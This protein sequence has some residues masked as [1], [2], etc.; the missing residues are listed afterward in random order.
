MSLY[1]IFSPPPPPPPTSRSRPVRLDP[2]PPPP[3]ALWTTAAPESQDEL[4][5]AL[6]NDDNVLARIECERRK[7]DFWS[8]L[9]DHKAEIEAN[10]SFHLRLETCLST[11]LTRLVHLTT[12]LPFAAFPF[13]SLFQSK[14]ISRCF[15]Y[16]QR[17]A[18]VLRSY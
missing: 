4:D 12:L 10:V 16:W 11:V 9:Q 18:L 2:P 5:R 14:E 13:H 15:L 8:F 6:S 7:K 3:K 17:V 1:N